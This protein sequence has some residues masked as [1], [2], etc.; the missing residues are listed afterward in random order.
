MKTGITKLFNYMDIQKV[1]TKYYNPKD[2]A[3]EMFWR[4]YKDPRVLE[5]ATW[6]IVED[7]ADPD[8]LG[9]L[10]VRAPLVFADAVTPWIPMVKP[11]A[12]KKFGIWTVPDIGDAVIIGFILSDPSK[13]F[14]MGC[15]PTKRTPPYYE[16]SPENDLKYIRTKSGLEVLMNDKDGEEE[17]VV[18]AKEGKMIIL[19]NKDGIQ[20]NNELGDM[21]IKAKKVTFESENIMLKSK[22]D[23]S[24]TAS[25]GSLDLI[26]RKALLMKAG[27]DAVI[28]GKKI[29]MKGNMGVTA[30]GM[31]IAKKDDMVVGVDTHDVQIPTNT[32]MQTIPMIP[33][34]YTG[35]LADKL[36]DDVTIND[37]AAAVKGSKSKNNPNHIPIGGVKFASNPNNEGEVSSGTC[38][39]VKIN[40]KEAAVLGAMVKTCSDPQPQETCTIV[41]VGASVALPIMP[42]GFDPEQYKRDGG[43]RI[44][45]RDPVAKKGQPNSMTDERSLDSPQWSSDTAIVGEEVTLSVNIQSQNGLRGATQFRIFKDGDDPE[46]DP[47]FATKNVRKEKGLELK[48]GKEYDIILKPDRIYLSYYF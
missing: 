27:G 48:T 40:G 23:T 46:V 32:G 47:P 21:T 2:K 36:S 39:S 16:K 31:Q 20:I 13:P 5:K 17:L 24:I 3:S 28:D 41:A 35:K 1:I 38:S 26:A 42:P 14:V 43:F 19:I 25:D 29:K 11:W 4:L 44:N 15:I 37:K 12:S 7:N 30:G 8:G 10:K 22:K 6:G 9:R 34:P 45:M 18:K 33:H